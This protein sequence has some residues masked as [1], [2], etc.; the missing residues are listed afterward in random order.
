MSHQGLLHTFKGPRVVT[1][2]LTGMK[3][4]LVKNFFILN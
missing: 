2:D 1:N 4:G 3:N